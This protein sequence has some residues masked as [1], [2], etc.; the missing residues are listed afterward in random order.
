MQRTKSVLNPEILG[1]SS[2]GVEK[3]DATFFNAL[4]FESFNDFLMGS[5]FKILPHFFD[6][7]HEFFL[8]FKLFLGLFLARVTQN[9]DFDSFFDFFEESGLVLG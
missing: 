5:H 1:L 9:Q 2:L 8:L 4:L 3:L 6:F 7:L